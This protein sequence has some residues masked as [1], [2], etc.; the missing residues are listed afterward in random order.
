MNI[1]LI[2]HVTSKF[3]THKIFHV[4]SEN[5][6]TSGSVS[7]KHSIVHQQVSAFFKHVIFPDF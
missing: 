5:M 6:F 4:I 2:V 7:I 3:L 1:Q